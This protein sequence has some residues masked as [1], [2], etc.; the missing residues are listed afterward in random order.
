M[1]QQVIPNDVL[2]TGS[3]RVQG[4]VNVPSGSFGNDDIEAGADIA[5]TKLQ[6]RRN[7]LYAQA[8]VTGTDNVD[9]D[10]AVAR[11]YGTTGTLI[12]C[13]AR[14]RVAPGGSDTTTVDVQKNGASVLS[15]PISLATADGVTYKAGTFSG[16]SLAAGDRLS[17]VI[18]ATG[19]TPGEGIEAVLVYDEL[20]D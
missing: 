15:A 3:L 14:N 9:E 7:I 10:R 20:A 16:T 18:N 6:H 13:Y 8:W 19:S 4:S 1:A 17:F 2:V 12:A 5:T 11:V